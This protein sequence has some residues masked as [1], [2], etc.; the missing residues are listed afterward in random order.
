MNGRERLLTM[1]AGKR[2]DRVPVA[3]FLYFNAVYEMFR[4]RPEIETFWDPPDFDPIERFVEYCGHFGFDVL[5]VL[6]SV[7][8]SCCGRTTSRSTGKC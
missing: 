8:D 5:H 1:L 2:A 3:S 4:Y 7:W 6:G